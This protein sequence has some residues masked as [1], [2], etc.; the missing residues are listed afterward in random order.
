MSSDFLT[1]DMSVTI[2]RDIYKSGIRDYGKLTKNM[3]CAV[4]TR[5]NTKKNTKKYLD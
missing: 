1:H 5:K 4:S 2:M 3:P